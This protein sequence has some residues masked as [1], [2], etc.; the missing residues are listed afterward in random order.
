MK[1][2]PYVSSRNFILLTFTFASMINFEWIFVYRLRKKYNFI[3]LHILIQLFSNICWKRWFFLHRIFCT[4][5]E[6]QWTITVGFI[7]GLSCI[8]LYVFLNPVSHCLYYCNFVISFKIQ[9]CV[10]QLCSSLFRV[11]F[12]VPCT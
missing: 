7:F 6:N 5:V 1:I 2:Y 3:L 11:L 8:D 12:W 9:K 10:F 4:L